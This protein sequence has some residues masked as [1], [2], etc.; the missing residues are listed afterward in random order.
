[1]RSYEAEL[2]IEMEAKISVTKDMKVCWKHQKTRIN[3]T[4]KMCWRK[5]WADLKNSLKT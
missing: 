3:G 1:M 5:A 4:W 2:K